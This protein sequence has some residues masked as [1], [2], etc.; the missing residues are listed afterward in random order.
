V[1][2]ALDPAV[3]F[4]LHA[5]VVRELQARLGQFLIG[6]LARFLEGFDFLAQLVHAEARRFVVGPVA[7]QVRMKCIDLREQFGD[8]GADTGPVL[9]R[10]LE[11]ALLSFEAGVPS[12]EF[13]LERRDALLRC[14]EVVAKLLDPFPGGLQGSAVLILVGLTLV[15]DVLLLANLIGQLVDLFLPTEQREFPTR[16]RATPHE[17]VVPEEKS[18]AR[19]E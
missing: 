8:L 14:L 9:G 4:T 15:E 6:A 10:F 1:R 5:T 12:S 7:P 16:T 2:Q 11:H 13:T 19:E 18:F 17:S 3:E